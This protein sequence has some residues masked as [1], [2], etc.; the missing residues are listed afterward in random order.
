MFAG[1]T[2]SCG[3][4]YVPSDLP[5]GRTS[6]FG[7]FVR[8]QAAADACEQVRRL[9]G[10]I[11][12]LELNSPGAVPRREFELNEQ[13]CQDVRNNILIR[14]LGRY[15]VD[16]WG[17]Y[18][19][20]DGI[21]RVVRCKF[22][23]PRTSSRKQGYEE[24]LTVG[25]LPSFRYCKARLIGRDRVHLY[26]SKTVTG[27]SAEKIMIA[28]YGKR[29][30]KPKIIS[31]FVVPMRQGCRIELWLAKE[32]GDDVIGCVVVKT[33]VTSVDGETIPADVL[34]DLE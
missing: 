15:G 9:A 33:Q 29:G 19:V 8:D 30:T 6:W 7:V 22:D 32:L 17:D 5:I 2:I 26:L 23:N 34:I 1:A 14:G 24:D 11:R 12:D 31:S 4:I 10:K 25:Y 18:F 3:H 13:F 16:P 21:K 20:I 28:A 27:S